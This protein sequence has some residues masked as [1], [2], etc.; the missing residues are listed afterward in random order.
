MH[1]EHPL[2][3]KPSDGTK[4]W[5]YM[6][7]T[8]LVDMLDSSTLFFTRSDKF[9]DPFEGQLSFANKKMRPTV[10]N[11]TDVSEEVLGDLDEFYRRLR[12]YTLI[13]CW[14]MNE[15]ESAAMWKLYLKSNEGIAIQS[16]YNRLCDS[17][18]NTESDVYIGKVH[19][20][21]YEEEFIP[22]WN[23]F[24][25]Y[26]YKRKSFEHEKELRAVIQEVPA[27][28]VED[29]LD[30]SILPR[31]FGA[32][33]NVDLEILIENVYVAPT[34]PQW[35]YDLVKSVMKKYGINRDVI[36]SNLYTNPF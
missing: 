31:G 28:P 5:R 1:D 12:M 16:T 3:E 34:S 14:H 23:A 21:D 29:K 25:P 4:I 30:W 10:Y 36:K 20:V 15:H 35:V 9:E 13:N 32:N 6:D 17:F 8:K 19:Y 33:V 18:C 22:E 27:H 24:S 7:F 2:F 26:V 11:G